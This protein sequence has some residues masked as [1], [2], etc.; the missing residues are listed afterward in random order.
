MKVVLDTNILLASIPKLS[1]YRPIFD[2]L[3]SGKFD[4][5]ISNEII[6]EYEEVI[7]KKTN[8]LIASNILELLMILR[9][10]SKQEVYYRWNLIQIDTDDNKFVDTAIAGS[11][12]FI[13]TNDSHFLVLNTIQFPVVKSI[14]IDE[15]L[16]LIN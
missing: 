1:K 14:G 13:V 16:N 2:S 15:F 12:D 7:S 6:T 11:A 8:S 5:I 9:N 3:I 10:V 4:L